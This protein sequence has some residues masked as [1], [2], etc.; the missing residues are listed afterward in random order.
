MSYPIEKKLVV[1]ISS[2]A[3]FDLRTEDEIFKNEG[4]EAYRK[5][6]V[7]NKTIVLEKGVGFPFIKR[8]LNINKIYSKEQPVEVVLL[9]RN[10]P[11]TGVRIFNS[12]RE[13][14]LDI[15]RAAFMSGGSA[16][17][18]IPAFNIS[19]FLSI[20]END[21]KEALKLKL[22]AGRILQ[23]EVY[24]DEATEL[25]IEIGRAHV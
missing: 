22:P 20:H 12:I 5:Y 7:D 24:D 6:Q 18:Y 3:L 1:G 9:S 13:Y 2:N 16:V 8:F 23:T 21:V 25:R 19:L 15:T 10:S 17:N 14:D 4:L 11:E